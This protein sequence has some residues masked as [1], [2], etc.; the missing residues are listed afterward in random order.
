MAWCF[1]WLPISALLL[2]PIGVSTPSGSDLIAHVVLFS[3]MTVAAVTF[4]RRPLELGLLA[5]LTLLGSVVLE[6]VQAVLPYRSFDPID[7]LANASGV[8]IGYGLAL[9]LLVLVIA[10]AGPGARRPR[11][12]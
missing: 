7:L 11:S 1:G 3:A 12:A 6:V 2:M 5:L 8:V 10:P 4:C 9:I